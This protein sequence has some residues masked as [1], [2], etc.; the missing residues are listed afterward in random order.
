VAARL[1]C[2]CLHRVAASSASGAV[3]NCSHPT[4]K[5]CAMYDH[6][7]W[8]VIAYDKSKPRPA[9]NKAVLKRIFA[10]AWP[11]RYSVLI[12]LVTIVSIALLDLV[13]PLLYRDLIDN[14]TQENPT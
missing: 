4:R 3:D 9:V 5:G 12:V 10:Y 6:S 8:S 1:C 14:K 2:N 11:Y 7:W 13:P